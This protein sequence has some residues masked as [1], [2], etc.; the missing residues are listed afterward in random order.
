MTLTDDEVDQVAA[1]VR[2]ARGSSALLSD[3]TD[4]YAD[5]AQRIA[6]RRPRCD[7]SG[8]CCRF[9]QYGHRLFVTTVELAA[10][11]AGLSADA[12]AK[13]SD[14]PGDGCLYQQ[15]GL[16][17]VHAVRPFGCRM[18]FCDPDATDWQQDQYEQFHLRLKELHER[19]G[20]PYR[21]V[22]WRQ[23]LRAVARLSY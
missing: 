7:R 8:A 10:F 9:E 19:H 11:A 23:G 6:D 21:Y 20:V 16:C 17:S 15:G 14:T 2:A 1:D 13:L 12:A 22:E 5:L 18:Y 3:V 4:L